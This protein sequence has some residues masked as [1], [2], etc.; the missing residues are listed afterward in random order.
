MDKW[1]RALVKFAH[2]YSSS[3]AWELERFGYRR[4]S[5]QL[6][7]RLLKNL[8]ESQFDHNEKFKKDI[9]TKKSSELRKDPLGR[10]RLGNAYWYQVD[11]EANL[12][13]YKEDPDD[14]TWEL[15]ARTEEELLTLIEQLRNGNCFTVIRTH[16]KYLID[17]F[18]PI[19]FTRP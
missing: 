4:I 17:K 6:K 12:R 14:E 2:T 11:E 1:E 16:N 8:I 10:D 9:N 19:S 5:I 3:D 7:T 18:K 13:V 15:V